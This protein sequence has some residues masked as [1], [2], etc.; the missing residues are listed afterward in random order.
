VHALHAFKGRRKEELTFKAGD[1]LTILEK[2]D[3][4]WY[5]ARDDQGVTGYVPI[6]FVDET[7]EDRDARKAR[8]EASAVNQPD[9]APSKHPSVNNYFG[10]IDD[11]DPKKPSSKTPTNPTRDTDR[12]GAG[13]QNQNSVENF[14][15]NQR[16]RARES[17]KEKEAR[18]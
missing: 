13:P 18:F 4:G 7:P 6:K 3:D 14:A 1:Q 10:W 8:E 11:D 9:P 15:K 2:V 17:K 16:K 12:G 5:R